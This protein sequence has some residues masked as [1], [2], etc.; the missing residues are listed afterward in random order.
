MLLLPLGE[1]IWIGSTPDKSVQRF[2]LSGHRVVVLSRNAAFPQDRVAATYSCDA[3]DFDDG[4]MA[5]LRSEARQLANVL[6]ADVTAAAAADPG[7]AWRV[8]DT[9]SKLFGDAVPG[10][11]TGDAAAFVS[12][13]DCGMAKVYGVWISVR[14]S[15]EEDNTPA[16][17]RRRMLSGPGRDPGIL[18]DT[19]DSDGRRFIQFALVFSLLKETAMEHWP[20]QG[21]R[22]VKDYFGAIRAL[23]SGI[24]R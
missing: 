14:R 17:F 7:L 1:A 6:G 22:S 9:T 3:V 20:I 15:T 21:P 13:D 16:G 10:G 12:R 8:S 11:A 4:E 19:C 2:D 5:R 23:A 18:A 24:P